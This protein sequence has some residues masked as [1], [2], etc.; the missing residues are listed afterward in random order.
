MKQRI[1]AEAHGSSPT[2]RSTV[3]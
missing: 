1:T 3:A 2:C